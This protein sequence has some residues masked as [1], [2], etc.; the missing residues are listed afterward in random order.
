MN[1]NIRKFCYGTGKSFILQEKAKHLVNT[2]NQNV[3]FIFGNEQQ[4]KTL[5]QLQLERDWKEYK[6]IKIMNK[7][8]IKVKINLDH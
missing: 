2:R 1:P 5:L 8:D 6:K 4:A 7:E 3:L